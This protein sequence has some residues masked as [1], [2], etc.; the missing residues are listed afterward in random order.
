MHCD[1]RRFLKSSIKAALGGASAFGAFGNL[2]LIESALAAT[3]S[4]FTDYKALVCVFLNGGNDSF[5]TVVPTAASA[6]RAAYAAQRGALAINSAALLPLMPRAGGGPS[7]GGVYGLHPVMPEMQALF[8]AGNAA[9]VANVGTLLRPTDQFAYNNR[10]DLPPQLFS[11]A[12]QTRYWQTS[13]PDD[14]SANGW[15]GRI[16]DLLYTNNPTALPTAFSIGEEAIFQ[17]A[18]SVDQYVTDVA[19]VSAIDSSVWQDGAKGV[20]DSLRQ[21]GMQTNM[22]Q[23]AYTASLGHTVDTYNAL[24]SALIRASQTTMKR[25]VFYV[26]FPGYDTHDN[27]LAQQGGGT[28]VP[29]GLLQDMSQ[30]INALYGALVSMGLGNNVTIFTTSDFGRTLSINGD[31]TDHGWGGH[32]FVV[33]GAV[34]GGRFYGRMPSLAVSNNPDDAGWGQIIP[35]TSVDQYAATLAAWFGVDASGID[36]VFPNL[37]N[38]PTAS[39]GFMA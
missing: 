29:V 8:N 22:L 23:R 1:R 33:G 31:G 13:R 19:G 34:L 16:A 25:Q 37:K 18:A 5:N 14:N 27:Q 35:T 3:P 38:F 36:T 6:N 9:I 4:T 2:A 7:D 28:N 26:G 20:F 30:S 32:H 21:T 17:R 12:D 11:H 10:I 15:G 24:A 39:L